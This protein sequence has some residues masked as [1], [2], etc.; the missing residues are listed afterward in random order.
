MLDAFLP[1][2]RKS[3]PVYLA[4]VLSLVL[5]TWQLRQQPTMQSPILPAGMV[6][7][8]PHIEL[9]FQHVSMQGREK[10]T[11]RWRIE[12][13]QVSASQN[14]QYIYF[15]KSPHGSFYNLKDWDPKDGAAPKNR[16]VD[17]TAN[18]AEY[19]SLMDQMII[20]G[21]ASF[22]TEEQDHLKSEH[23]LYLARQHSVQMDKPVEL[24]THDKLILRSLQATAD[25]QMERV[26][27]G[28][29]VELISPLKN[30]EKPL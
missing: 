13:D 1:H 24:T 5:G 22:V 15:E 17:W 11:V 20:S 6:K 21:S 27:L 18:R 26:E 3:W 12:A 19:D 7:M 16:S 8:E 28:G 9:Q 14:Q 4:L 25:T 30:Q 10:G 29:N 23:V 2:L